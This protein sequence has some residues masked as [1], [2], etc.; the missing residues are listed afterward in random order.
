MTMKNNNALLISVL[1]SFI[2][3]TP[4]ASPIVLHNGVNRIDLLG[5]GSRAA[6]SV[7]WRGNFNGHGHTDVAFSIFAKSD[8]GDDKAM[9][10]VVPFFGSSADSASMNDVFATQEG[11]DCTLSDLRVLRRVRT[12][13]EAIIAR[14][15]FAKSFAD[16]EPVHFD[17]Y[18]LRRNTEGAAGWPPYY[19]Q[20]T[21]TSTSKRSFCDVNEAFGSELG[22]GVRGVAHGGYAPTPSD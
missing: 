8:R 5:N 17:Y 7:A 4:A 2:A 14:R 1:V 16:A 6:A 13:V 10:L 18:E 22:L 3:A 21:R 12:P 9:W 15:D 20:F 19:F 11:A